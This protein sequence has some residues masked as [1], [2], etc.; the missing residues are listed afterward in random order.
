MN[1][2]VDFQYIPLNHIDAATGRYNCDRSSNCPATVFDSCLVHELCDPSA[3]TC[4]ATRRLQLSSYLACFEGPYANTE[5]LPASARTGLCFTKAYGAEA[6]LAMRRV[7]DC[8]ANDAVAVQSALNKTRAPMYAKLGPEPGLFPHIFLDG[9]HF[10]HN[11]WA[12]LLRAICDRNVAVVSRRI[13]ACAERTA[14]FTLDVVTSSCSAIVLR[15]ASYCSAITDA[16]NLAASEY[17]FPNGWQ[18]DGAAG[19]GNNPSYVNERAVLQCAYTSCAEGGPTSKSVTVAVTL[20]GLVA[21][22]QATLVGAV[23]DAAAP[24]R[25]NGTIG[26]LTLIVDRL[27]DTNFHVEGVANAKLQIGVA[28]A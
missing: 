27:V 3:D 25:V 13:A 2:A 12:A 16:A 24:P 9:T 8:V 7:T 6:P 14:T 26:L 19:Q 21:G 15:Q 10:D 1:D 28:E 22:L 5:V 11:S 4:N 17:A 23:A 20:R 18:T